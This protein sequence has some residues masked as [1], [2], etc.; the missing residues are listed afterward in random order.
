M[1]F[2]LALLTIG[3]FFAGYINFPSAKLGDFLGQSPSLQGAYE[4]ANTAAAVPH[5]AEG[6]G[7]IQPEGMGHE[8]IVSGL[9]ILSGAISAFGIFLAYM[10]HLQNR[11]RGE[12]VAEDFGPITRLLEAK[13]YVDEIYQ[14]FIVNPLRMLGEFAY[15]FDRWIIDML[16]NL[17]G[18]ICQLM[19]YFLKFS[20]QR[21]YLQ[22]YAA[23]MLLGLAAILLFVF[24]H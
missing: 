15:N 17:V 11:E 1:M 14:S 8:P 6:M 18:W 9:M 3:A 22:G 13:Y 2:P 24:M 21:G 16:V 10:Q 20:T 12:R 4:V 5:L 7:Q 19:G 23:M